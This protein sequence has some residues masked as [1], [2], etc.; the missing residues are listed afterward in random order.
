MDLFHSGIFV[1]PREVK[2]NKVVKLTYEGELVQSG[3]DEIY[4]HCG[5]T[6]YSDS[7]ENVKDYKMK[8]KNNRFYSDITV[9]NGSKLNLCF[10]DSADNWDNNNGANYSLDLQ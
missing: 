6:N 3:A 8:R 2:A 1:T 5:V 9:P 10:R 7:W 4:V